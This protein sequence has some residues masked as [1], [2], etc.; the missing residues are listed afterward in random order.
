[1]QQVSRGIKRLVSLEDDDEDMENHLKTLQTYYTTQQTMG[2]SKQP[3]VGKIFSE[4]E[5]EPAQEIKPKKSVKEFHVFETENPHYTS[6]YRVIPP[7]NEADSY[8]VTTESGV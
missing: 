3:H 6:I 5:P 2:I 8:S 7:T 4:P 1:M